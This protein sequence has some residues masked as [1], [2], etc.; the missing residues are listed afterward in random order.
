MDQVLASKTDDA[1]FI[2][3][4]HLMSSDF[5]TCAMEM[6]H[7]HMYHIHSHMT[8]KEITKNYKI[9]ITYL[10]SSILNLA[11]ESAVG[12]FP[13]VDYSSD[14]GVFLLC[15]SACFGDLW[16]DATL[17]DLPV[18]GAVSVLL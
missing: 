4:T 16:L 2:P 8:K 18:V 13:L 17:C 7:T 1:S 9:Q 5:H 12:K 6:P 3:G 14:S 10:T 11:C 15:L